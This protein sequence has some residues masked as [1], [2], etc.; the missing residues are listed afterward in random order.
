MSKFSWLLVMAWRDGR[1]N[2]PKLILFTSAIFIGIASLVAI[3]SFRDNL[4]NDINN[5]SKEL[6]GADLAVTNSQAYPDSIKAFLDTL[7]EERCIQYSF[8]TMAYFSK[9]GTGR[10]LNVKGYEGNFPYYGK[11]ETDPVPAAKSFVNGFNAIVDKTVMLQFDSEIGDSVKV[12]SK[13][14][15][16][17]GRLLKVPGRAEI[18]SSISPVIY[19][20]I[21][22]LDSEGLIQKGSRI[23]YNYYFRISDKKKLEVA[24]KYLEELS[25]TSTLAYSTVDTRKA[26]TGQILGNLTNFLNMVAFIALLLGCIGVASSVHIY[27]KEKVPSVAI[28][29]CLGA[30]QQ[31]AFM[32]FFIQLFA[33]GLVGSIAGAVL[34]SLIQILLPKILADILPVAINY[35][36]SWSSV[37]Q[38]IFSGVL[39]TVLFGAVPL[40][41]IR[42]VSPLHVIREISGDKVKFD[43]LVVMV[44]ALIAGFILVFSRLQIGSWKSSAYFSLYMVLSVGV[45]YLLSLGIMLAIRKF[46][47]VGLNY[48][49]RQS[50]ANLYRPGNQTV[51]L[52]LCIGL[53]AVFIHVLYMIQGI[54][55]KQISV[56]SDQNQPNMVLFDIQKEQKDSLGYLISSFNLPLKQVAPI[57]TMR[58]ESINGRSRTELKEDTTDKI[59]A[60]AVEGE[61][62]VTYRDELADNEKVTQGKW[63]SSVKPNEKIIISVDERFADGLGLKLNDSIDF[64]VQGAMIRTYIGSLRD[65]EWNRMQSSFSV[66]FPNG[67]L[68]EAPQ[69]FAFAL[70]GGDDKTSAKFQRQL[71]I[72]FPNI[73][74]FDLKL[75]FMTVNEVIKKVEF[76]IRF[77]AFISIATGI[78]VFISSIVISRYQRVKESVLLRTLGASRLQV[79]WI[80]TL[81]YLFIGLIS[82]LMAGVL[83]LGAGWGLTKFFFSTPFYPDYLTLGIIT[84]S[85]AGATT[86]LG[87][88]NSVGIFSRPPLEVLRSEG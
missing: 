12:G 22:Y 52:V 33:M 77:M 9:T 83:A 59:P 62:R 50:L 82:A 46:M 16:I 45:L 79:T 53:G 56:S 74:V 1:R 60:W 29:R 39:V 68:E 32:I 72:Q 28:L 7:G 19:I 13:S 20:P 86:L 37:W 63:V 23:N 64:N 42:K 80:Y 44:Y 18:Q 2:I 31:D 55:L 66:V 10:L 14:Y 57:V 15:R 71:A 8:A 36:V 85:I 70:Q 69:T 67:V 43:G 47:P 51:I 21:K 58:V 17:A 81:E 24:V 75:L 49:V 5:Q 40:L 30:S 78:L 73:S 11:L 87:W 6:L 76:V 61:Y 65:I 38:G 25:K 34:G 54:L 48:I 26:T 84:F 3:N 4:T 41:R 35:S 88:L 27:I